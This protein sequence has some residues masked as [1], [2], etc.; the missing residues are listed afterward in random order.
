MQLINYLLA[1][2]RFTLQLETTKLLIYC[3]FL[4]LKQFKNV[5]KSLKIGRY[6]FSKKIYHGC[7]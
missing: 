4:V 1:Y 7:V 2:W 6:Y 3:Y 5:L